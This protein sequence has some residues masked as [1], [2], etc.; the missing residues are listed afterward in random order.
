MMSI[1]ILE[2]KDGGDENWKGY[3]DI[4]RIAVMAPDEREARELAATTGI[5]YRGK[6]EGQQALDEPGSTPWHNRSASTCRK[7]SDD[8]NACVLA[9]QSRW[10]D[11][12]DAVVMWK[13]P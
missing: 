2:R 1:W 13:A 9:I 8:P 12:E 5:G 7:I 6:G 3:H 4:D 10:V 11:V